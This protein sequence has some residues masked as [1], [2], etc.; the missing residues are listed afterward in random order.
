MFEHA[1]ASK[2]VSFN[3]ADRA[4][5]IR[6]PAAAVSADWF[7]RVWRSAGSGPRFLCSRGSAQ[8]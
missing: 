2:P 7:K 5:P 3:Y 1:A 6:L 8:I 4:L